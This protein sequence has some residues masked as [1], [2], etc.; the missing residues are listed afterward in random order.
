MKDLQQ[1]FEEKVNKTD[2]CWLWTGALTRDGYG[3]I[4]AK[5][6]AHGNNVM[7]RAHRVSYFLFI[8]PIPD[9]QKVLHNCDTP[10]CVNPE[11]LKLGDLKTN[12]KD[13]VSRCRHK[14]KITNSLNPLSM[15]KATGIRQLYATGGYKLNELAKMFNTSVPQIS[16]VINNKIWR[17]GYHEPL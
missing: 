2:S 17:E 1:R 8:G 9:G 10:A 12:T 6:K 16:R 5:I 7:C 3:H 15:E 11:H 14:Y 13:M 4:R